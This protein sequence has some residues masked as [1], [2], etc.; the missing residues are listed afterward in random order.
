VP[1]TEA[2]TSETLKPATMPA[3]TLGGA[4][5]HKPGDAKPGSMPTIEKGTP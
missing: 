2:G 4:A 5:A 1:V 3:A